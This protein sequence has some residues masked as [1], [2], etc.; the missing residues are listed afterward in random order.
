MVDVNSATALFVA[1]RVAVHL[2]YKFPWLPSLRRVA[3]F[4]AACVESH[5]RVTVARRSSWVEML[6]RSRIDCVKA[7]SLS[8]IRMGPVDGSTRL[9][10]AFRQCLVLLQLRNMCAMLLSV[11][12]HAG[13]PPPGCGKICAPARRLPKT[14]HLLKSSCSLYNVCWWSG[15]CPCL[16]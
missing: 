11:C 5:M 4:I 8:V 15:E 6:L 16:G 10:H 2:I 12:P 3:A 13:Q 14:L 7:C 9:S 1:V